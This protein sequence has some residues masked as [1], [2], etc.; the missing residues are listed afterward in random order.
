MRRDL[1]RRKPSLSTMVR[2]E[3]HQLKLALLPLQKFSSRHEYFFFSSRRRHTRCSRDWSSDVCSS[4]LATVIMVENIFRH[5][6]QAV[7]RE[8]SDPETRLSEKLNRI[9]AAAV[10]VDRPIFFSVMITID[11]KSVV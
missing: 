4:D 2:S 6:A 5:L 10:E 11:R 3:R 8:I 7:R 9:L 1:T